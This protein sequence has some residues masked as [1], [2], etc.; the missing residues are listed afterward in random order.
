M[1]GKSESRLKKRVF[2]VDD[3]AVFRDGLVRILQQEKDLEV[4]GE[5]TD[6]GEAL[7]E[8]EKM[9][10]D[11]AIIDI[12][13]EGANGIDLTKT[14]RARFPAMRILVL[15]MHKES[16]Y[17]ER[18][19]RAGAN[20]YIMKRESGATLLEAVRRILQGSIYVSEKLNELLLHRV[21]NPGHEHGASPVDQ[22]SDRELEVF[23]LIGH[24]YGTRQIAEKLN[25]SMKTV[26]SHREHIRDKLDIVNTFELV[27]FA[28]H[29][30]KQEAIAE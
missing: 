3:H 12:S 27:R 6:A 20:G 7:K 11:L 5:A 15:S 26:E 2:V 4:C 21:S 30:I 13:L 1:A 29:W 10:P 22:L 14:V 24:G 18:A 17:A 19:L 23:Q 28:I 8:L 9:K 16:L 25:L